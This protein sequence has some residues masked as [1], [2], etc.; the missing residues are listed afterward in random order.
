MVDR[1]GVSGVPLL[2]PG[3]AARRGWRPAA[4]PE[5]PRAVCGGRKGGRLQGPPPRGS[6]AT[7]LPPLS[8]P[9][10]EVPACP[11][12]TFLLRHQIYSVIPTTNL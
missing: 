6:Q 9:P 2:Y 4:G 5:D 7:S 1:A 10:V 11:D 8:S 12:L 3:W